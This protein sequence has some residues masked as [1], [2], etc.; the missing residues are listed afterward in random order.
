MRT[1]PALGAAMNTGNDAVPFASSGVVAAAATPVT[2][3]LAPPAATEPEPEVRIAAA[4][5]EAKG[6][7]AR[8][9]RVVEVPEVRAAGSGL[10]PL[11]ATRDVKPAKQ[12]AK[13]ERAAAK[14]DRKAAK[15]SR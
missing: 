15:H 8:L 6:R 7:R 4:T 1:S 3:V 12:E 5:T 13:A 14:A 11:V 10:S 2:A 9:A